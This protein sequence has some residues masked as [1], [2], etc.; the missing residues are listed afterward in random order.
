MYKF[1]LNW[2]T[3]KIVIG[4]FLKKLYFCKIKCN[5]PKI[6]FRI[7]K[8]LKKVKLNPEDWKNEFDENSMKNVN[9][10]ERERE[11][12]WCLFVE[13]I[14]EY[15]NNL[16]IWRNVLSIYSSFFFGAFGII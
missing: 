3:F 13:I 11:S 15:K 7:D 9:G 16:R 8:K 4:E 12:R 2:L 5:L 6:L 14:F 1:S 10:I